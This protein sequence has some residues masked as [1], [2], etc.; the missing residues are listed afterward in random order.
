MYRFPTMIVLI[1]GGDF[2]ITE[3]EVREFIRASVQARID[4]EGMD[5]SQAMQ[6][7]AQHFG[8]MIEDVASEM[9]G[10]PSPTY[11]SEGE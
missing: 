3:D 2:V 10:E 9:D 5:A 7:T 1:W 8:A 4:A 11:E 6:E